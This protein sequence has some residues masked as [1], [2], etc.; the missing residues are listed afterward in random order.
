MKSRLARRAI[1]ICLWVAVL[2]TTALGHAQTLPPPEPAP[3]IHF[4][5]TAGAFTIE[6]YP[7][8]APATVAHIVE[9]V[10]KGF[11]DG[12]RVHRAIPGFVVQFGDP[13]T[14]DETK[15][16]LWGLGAAASSGNPIGVAEV[17][18]TR[19][20]RVGAVGVAHMGEPSRAD[21]QIYITLVARPDLDGH[22]AIFGQVIGGADVPSQL[23]VG[24]TILRATVVP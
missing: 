3:R 6:T 13:Q 16:R 23:H 11:Y 18:M 17:V 12:Q 5:T 1:L 14:R 15:R 4:E 7:L 19:K 20:H 22:Y 24:D 8:D 9:L 10:K 21:S 2:P